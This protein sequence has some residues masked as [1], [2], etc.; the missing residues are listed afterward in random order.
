VGEAPDLG[1]L[2]M[3]DLVERLGW[4]IDLRTGL[5]DRSGLW[6]LGT[7]TTNIF[8]TGLSGHLAGTISL[9]RVVFPAPDHPSVAACGAGRFD[10]TRR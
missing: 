2:R 3:P 6:F 10:L 8:G 1:Y 9:H 7:S 5:G 4:D